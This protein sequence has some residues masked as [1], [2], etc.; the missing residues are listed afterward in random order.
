MND[1][2]KSGHLLS[3]TF[4]ALNTSNPTPP[5]HITPCLTFD[6][7]ETECI[8]NTYEDGNEWFAHDSDL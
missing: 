1:L 3:S 6:N 5:F 8:Y 7:D 4:T 2:N